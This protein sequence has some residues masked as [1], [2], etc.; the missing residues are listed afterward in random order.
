MAANS[1]SSV[2]FRVVRRTSVSGSRFW[3]RSQSITTVEPDIWGDVVVAR[4]RETSRTPPGYIR[5]SYRDGYDSD[6]NDSL[7][8]VT[9]HMLIPDPEHPRGQRA[10]RQ[11]HAIMLSVHLACKIVDILA[12]P[13]MIGWVATILQDFLFHV[14]SKTGWH[15]EF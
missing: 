2:H 6:D 9:H 4:S 13:D 5:Q 7:G 3:F 11:R 10:L 14:M 8:T 1:A 12:T 15:L